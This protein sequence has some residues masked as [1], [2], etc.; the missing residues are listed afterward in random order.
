MN[1]LFVVALFVVLCVAVSAFNIWMAT[2]H[3]AETTPEA[4]G[5]WYIYM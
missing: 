3:L 1:E 4:Y 5:W 2:R